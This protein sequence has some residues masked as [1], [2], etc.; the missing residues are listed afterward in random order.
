VFTYKIDDGGKLV[1][2]RGFWDFD[3][4]VKSITPAPEQ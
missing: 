2:L 1:S 3:K 4:T